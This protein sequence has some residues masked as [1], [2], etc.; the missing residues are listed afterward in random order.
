MAFPQ[1]G[2]IRTTKNDKW[3]YLTIIGAKFFLDDSETP[4]RFLGGRRNTS[5]L[6]ILLIELG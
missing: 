3:S 4:I 2:P 5:H 6:L 1:I